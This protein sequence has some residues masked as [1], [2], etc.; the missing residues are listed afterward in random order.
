M[1]RTLTGGILALVGSIW[2][3]AIMICAGGNL[4]SEWDLA[5]G[6]FWSTVVAMHLMFPFVVSAALAVFGIIVI[7]VELFRKEK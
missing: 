3:L 1:K 6:R 5:L 7:L 2:A 4:V